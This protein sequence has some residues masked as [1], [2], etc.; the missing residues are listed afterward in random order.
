MLG[1]AARA[2]L[3]TSNAQWKSFAN[4]FG[5]NLQQPPQ[6]FFTQYDREL[7][8]MLDA[9]ISCSLSESSVAN[10]IS[11]VTGWM[12]SQSLRLWRIV[13]YLMVRYL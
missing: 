11:V 9:S 13:P 12:K 4:R 5:A 6:K 3:V 7:L 8:L 1:A 2:G 10:L